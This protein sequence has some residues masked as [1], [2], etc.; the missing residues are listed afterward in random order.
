MLLVRIS[1][2][3]DEITNERCSIEFEFEVWFEF[4]CFRES[5]P[6]AYVENIRE[7]KGCI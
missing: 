2:T 3:H 4:D 1:E 7:M 5:R 6:E